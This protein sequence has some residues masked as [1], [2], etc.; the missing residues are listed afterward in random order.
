MKQDTLTIREKAIEYWSKVHNDVKLQLLR[1][2][3]NDWGNDPIESATDEEIGRVYMSVHGLYDTFMAVFNGHIGDAQTKAIKDFKAKYSLAIYKKEIAN[4]VN[5]GIMAIFHQKP[6]EYT[7]YFVDTITTYV[8]QAN[9]NKYLSEHPTLSKEPETIKEGDLLESIT[10][11]EWEVWAE[12]NVQS[13]DGRAICS[14]GVNNGNPK[15][16]QENIANARLISQAPTL[17]KE[18]K[19]L[20]ASNKE[21]EVENEKLKRDVVIRGTL[22]LEFGYLQCEKGNN[23]D[24]AFINYNKLA[25]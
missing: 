14:C 18:N 23:L 3:I 7:Q 19:R 5:K 20:S 6:N 17:A 16:R 1:E 12:L 8:N 2:H 24:M 9:M 13:T 11:G 10:Q 15:S 25:K 21:L 22:A 4:F